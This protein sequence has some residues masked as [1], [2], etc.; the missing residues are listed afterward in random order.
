[1]NLTISG[2]HLEVTPA[3]REYVQNKLMRV[4]RHFD[5]VVNITVTLSFE[6]S[7][8]KERR[9]KAEV[10]LKVKGKEIH[11]ENYAADMYASIDEMVDKVDRQVGR[12]KEKRQAH[13]HDSSNNMAA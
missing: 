2:H 3:L 8:E 11:A 4:V 7:R 10:T 1:M 13:Q 6:K 9:H 5:K 12:Y